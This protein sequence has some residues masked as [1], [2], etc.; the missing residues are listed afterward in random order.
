MTRSRT[1]VHQEARSSPPKQPQRRSMPRR[2]ACASNPMNAARSTASTAA[3]GR[4]ITPVTSAIP[5][6]SSIPTTAAARIGTNAGGTTR[7][8]MEKRT[9]EERTTSGTD[10]DRKGV[11][12]NV[13]VDKK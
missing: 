6:N 12:V 5:A 4:S 9:V 7:P 1:T 8:A 10:T 3:A 2:S 11:K 13:D